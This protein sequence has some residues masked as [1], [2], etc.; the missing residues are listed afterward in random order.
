MA[1]TRHPYIISL[2]WAVTVWTG[3][4]APIRAISSTQSMYESFTVA[5]GVTMQ[6]LVFGTVASA[7]GQ[8]DVGKR[9]RMQKLETIHSY[10]RTRGVPPFVRERVID[11]YD[12][13]Y[14]R[15]PPATYSHTC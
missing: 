5:L 12:H 8:V 2:H 3:L 6:S 15:A 9:V 13:M 14:A 1:A 11:Y 7:V 10:V 4:G